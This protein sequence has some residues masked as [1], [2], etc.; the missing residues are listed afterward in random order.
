MGTAFPWRATTID[1]TSNPDAELGAQRCS[2]AMGLR[3]RVGAKHHL[4]DAVSIAQIDEDRP[5]MV[6][7]AVHP[8]HQDD[9]LADVLFAELAAGVTAAELQNL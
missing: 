9:G 8:P 5:T 2:E 3:V 4:G 1:V 7:A 6:P